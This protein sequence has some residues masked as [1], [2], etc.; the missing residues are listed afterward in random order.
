[1]NELYNFIFIHLYGLNLTR[2][3]K[4]HS[5]ANSLKQI[6]LGFCVKGEPKLRTFVFINFGHGHST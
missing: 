5:K 1:M 6:E 2:K 3:H 4:L